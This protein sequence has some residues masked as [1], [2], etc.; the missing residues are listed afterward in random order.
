[1]EIAR[2]KRK[3]W[4]D[5]TTGINY[6]DNDTIAKKYKGVRGCRYPNRKCWRNCVRRICCHHCDREY[7]CK[8]RCLSDIRRCQSKWGRDV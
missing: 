4:Q 6:A 7:Q 5:W 8:D 3:E 2:P 1:M